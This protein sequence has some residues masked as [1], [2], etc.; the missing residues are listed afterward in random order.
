MT[1]E[2]NRREFVGERSFMFKSERVD[3][4]WSRYD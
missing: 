3:T 1:R 2:A 4:G